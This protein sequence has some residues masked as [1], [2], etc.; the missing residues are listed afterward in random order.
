MKYYNLSKKKEK[1]NY[2]IVDILNNFQVFLTLLLKFS[3][4]QKY[5]QKLD[6][7]ILPLQREASLC[8]RI[9]TLYLISVKTFVLFGLFANLPLSPNSK[10]QEAYLIRSQLSIWLLVFSL[11]VPFYLRVQRVTAR[12]SINQPCVV[13]EHSKHGQS[14]LLKFRRT[15]KM[16]H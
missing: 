9:S 14:E 2:V 8:F 4:F 5:F 11:N 6:I 12:C 3:E 1:K 13:I 16:S 7:Y 15:G 10:L